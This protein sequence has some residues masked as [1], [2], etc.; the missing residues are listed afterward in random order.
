MDYE[1][2]KKKADSLNNTIVISDGRGNYYANREHPYWS[3]KQGNP[4]IPLDINGNLQ[5]GYVG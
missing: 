4:Y 3:G 5:K 2:E 1:L